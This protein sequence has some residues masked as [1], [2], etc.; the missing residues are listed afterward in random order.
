VEERTG[1]C[2]ALAYVTFAWSGVR[3]GVGGVLL[4]RQIDDYGI[5]K[6]TI[7]I[8]FLTLSLGFA[9]GGLLSG[10][11]IERYGMRIA[12]TAGAAA[13]GAASL[14]LATRPPFAALVVV[15][16][17]TGL[18][19]GLLESLL[20]A[21]LSSLPNATSLLNR[22]HA[23]FGVGA[24][25]GPLL[26]NWMLSFTSWPVVWLVLAIAVVPIGVGTAA[27]YPDRQRAVLDG[28]AKAGG[29]LL[30]VVLRQRAVLLGTALLAV[31]VG[32]EIGAG[33]WSFSYLVDGRGLGDG[34]ASLLVSG[35]WLGLTVGRFVISPLA[36]RI[37]AGV[38]SM[39]SACMVGIL[40]TG[41]FVWMVPWSL[42]A[43]GL[44]VVLGFFLGPIFPTVMALTPQVTESR[45][46]PAAIGVMNAGAVGGGAA[47]P[48]LA[49]AV[50]QGAG[51]WTLLPFVIALAF[52]QLAVWWR[53][54]VSLRG[55]DAAAAPIP[56]IAD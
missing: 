2:V 30:G 15:G 55:P 47:L 1:L 56:A 21:Y 25:L 8:T 22:L 44:L 48:W 41:F 51:V 23:F 35:Y 9:L 54:A 4:P 6:A 38:S 50:A 12:L 34:F 3:A 39:M 32:I 43:G 36:I 11:L 14:Y 53:F 19:V 45:Y 27:W 31:Y 29:T 52:V 40:A 18:G 46:V 24:L 5:D 20:N 7:G 26:A 13:S 16:L 33:S 28:V 42:P 37:G 10:G 49:G 17:L